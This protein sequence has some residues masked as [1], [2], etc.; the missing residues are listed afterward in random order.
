MPDRIAFAIFWTFLWTRTFR[1]RPGIGALSAR[2]WWRVAGGVSLAVLA[3][4]GVALAG[5]DVNSLWYRRLPKP[6]FQPPDWAFPVVW[7]VIYPTLAATTALTIADLGDDETGS[8]NPAQRRTYTALLGA[9]LALNAAWP[10]VFHHRRSLVGTTVVSAGM[11][12]TAAELVRRTAQANPWRAGAL[13]LYPA[14]GV[15]ATAINGWID[16][17]RA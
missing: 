13:A 4:A 14:W 15:L 5:T 7:N 17:K 3:A 2:R 8:D 9:N 6:P 1:A 11:T 10:W 16:A 12:V